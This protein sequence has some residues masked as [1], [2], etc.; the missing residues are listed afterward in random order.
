MEINSNAPEPVPVLPASK[1]PSV[2]AT[3]KSTTDTKRKVSG[4]INSLGL[5]LRQRWR[6]ARRV[7][8]RPA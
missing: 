5:N 7:Y 3:D 2:S 4:K 6:S 8:D 1:E